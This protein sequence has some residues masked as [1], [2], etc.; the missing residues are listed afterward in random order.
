MSPSNSGASLRTPP[1]MASS[2]TLRFPSNSHSRQTWSR[3]LPVGSIPRRPETSPDGHA[4]A[5]RVEA[6]GS[7]CVSG[8]LLSVCFF[9]PDIRRSDRREPL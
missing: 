3:A 6:V 7:R 5:R 8:D 1:S 4:Q 9:S 2:I